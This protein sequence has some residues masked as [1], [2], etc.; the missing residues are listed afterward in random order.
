MAPVHAAALHDIHPASYRG[1]SNEDNKNTSYVAAFG[2]CGSEHQP[3]GRHEVD[4]QLDQQS[5]GGKIVIPGVPPDKIPPSPI[6]H[7]TLRYR[8]P[9][10]QGLKCGS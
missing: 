9:L 8:L 5:L 6:V 4:C 1:S 7:R 2:T 3:C 10:N